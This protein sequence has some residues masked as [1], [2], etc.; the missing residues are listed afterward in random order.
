MSQ[1]SGVKLVSAF[2][3]KEAEHRWRTASW[4]R[5]AAAISEPDAFARLPQ[6]RVLEILV[7]RFGSGSALSF[8][9]SV[10]KVEL[11]LKS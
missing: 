2:H 6:E 1:T 4:S 10:D 5:A 7:A 3:V 8:T 9:M 11:C